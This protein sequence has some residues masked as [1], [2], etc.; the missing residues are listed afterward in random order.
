[1]IL[2]EITDTRWLLL[3]FPNMF[4]NWWLYCVIVAQFFPAIYPRSFKTAA[5]PFVLL[6]IPKLF[7]GVAAALSGG[8]TLGL[9]QAQPAGHF[10]IIGQAGV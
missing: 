7:Q 3:V 8:A 2:F 5:I 9:D 6:L 1:V 10:V 4:E